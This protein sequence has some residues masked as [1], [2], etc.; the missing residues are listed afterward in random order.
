VRSHL[1]NNEIDPNITTE[2]AQRRQQQL[3]YEIPQMERDLQHA[4]A[5]MKQ[6]I[7]R[8]MGW[9]KTEERKLRIVLA[10]RGAP[11]LPPRERAEDP[12]EKE[13]AAAA[14]FWRE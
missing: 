2:Q 7:L 12:A 9:I 13:R 10:D 14:A 8:C 4:D 3:A 1:I 11:L 6:G 5:A